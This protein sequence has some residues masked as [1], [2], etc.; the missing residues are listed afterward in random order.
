VTDTFPSLLVGGLEQCPKEVRLLQSE[1]GCADLVGIA[2][3]ISSQP[4]FLIK[5]EINKFIDRS[6]CY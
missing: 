1:V 4:M 6:F 2:L 3:S 5:A